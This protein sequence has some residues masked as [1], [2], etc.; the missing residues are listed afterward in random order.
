VISG[1]KFFV[2]IMIVMRNKQTRAESERKRE[3]RKMERLE[4]INQERINK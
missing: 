2:K 4:K 1:W 3:K